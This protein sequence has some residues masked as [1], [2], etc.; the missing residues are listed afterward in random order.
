MEELEKTGDKRLE[1][2]K[3]RFYKHEEEKNK[4]KMAKTEE[5]GSNAFDQNLK[6]TDSPSMAKADV[7]IDVDSTSVGSSS[8]SP[9]SSCSPARRGR[10][11]QVLFSR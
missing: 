5:T 4:R 7:D 10:V 6:V 9:S 2:V 8:S 3:E 11:P 1:K